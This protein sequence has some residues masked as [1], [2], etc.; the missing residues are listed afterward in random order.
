MV[1]KEDWTDKEIE[2]LRNREIDFSDIPELT[3]A[4]LATLKKVVPREHF[5]VVAIK[6]A[7]SIKLDSDVL[8]HY[9]SKGKGYQTRINKILRQEMLRETAP[10]Y[11]KV[12]DASEDNE[13]A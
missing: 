12:N 2:A 5:K 9:K 8:E 11:G 1:N 3:P 13:N 7:I 6:K 10:P 4:Y